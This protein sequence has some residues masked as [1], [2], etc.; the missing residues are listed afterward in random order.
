[1]KS[2]TLYLACLTLTAACVATG[3]AQAA[4]QMDPKAVR[5]VALTKE[6]KATYSVFVWNVITPRGAAPIREWAAEFH[7]G[8]LHRVE[9]PRDRIVA[10][11]KLMTGTQLTIETGEIQTGPEFARVAC[12]VSQRLPFLELTYL[13]TEQGRWGKVT[14]IRVKDEATIRSYAIDPRGIIVAQTISDLA[15]TRRLTMT[16]RAVRNTVPKD[17]F[18]IGSLQRSLVDSEFKLAPEGAADPN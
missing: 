10:N 15:G 3:G 8:N 16:A 14:R 13:R 11:C 2:P 4:G 12:G 6:T 18:S 7:S 17:A 1:M 9:T 5:V